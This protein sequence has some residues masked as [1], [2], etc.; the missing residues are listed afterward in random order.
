M[1]RWATALCLGAALAAPAASRDL[2]RDERLV[3]EEPPFSEVLCV[4]G[5]VDTRSCHFKDLFYNLDTGRFRLY[6]DESTAAS[7]G[8]VNGEQQTAD[9]SFLQLGVY[10]TPA[11]QLTCTKRCARRR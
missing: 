5:D 6:T 2:L 3:L 10:V 7:L 4:G 8:W 11:L 9:H 1:A